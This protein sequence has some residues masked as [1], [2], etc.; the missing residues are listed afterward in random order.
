[1]RHFA[2]DGEELVVK[3]TVTSPIWQYFRFFFFFFLNQTP[4]ASQVIFPKFGA[5]TRKPEAGSALTRFDSS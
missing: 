2:R 1:M 3:K 5:G 4:K